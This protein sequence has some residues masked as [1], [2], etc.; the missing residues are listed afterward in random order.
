MKASTQDG[1]AVVKLEFGTLP[2]A[3]ESLNKHL[4]VTGPRRITVSII[5]TYTYATAHLCHTLTGSV[6]GAGVSRVVPA[7]LSADRPSF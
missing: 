3:S 1:E 4:A 2:I 5:F 7:T 6:F